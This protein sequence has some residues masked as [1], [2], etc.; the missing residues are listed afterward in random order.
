MSWHRL[1]MVVVALFLIGCSPKIAIRVDSIVDQGK[2]PPEKKYILY[3]RMKGTS[4]NDL[5]FREYSKYFREILKKHGY[6]QENQAESA[7]LAIYFSYGITGG[8]EVHHT[9]TRPVYAIVGGETVDIRETETDAEGKKI[10]T[11]KTVTIPTRRRVVGLETRRESYR[12]FTAHAV[13]EA[14][15]INEAK[16]HTD[17]SMQTLWKTTITTTSKLNDLRRIMPMMAAASTP[18]LGKNTGEM[19]TVKLRDNDDRVLE[20]KRL[21]SIA[22]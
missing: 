5:Y 15:E 12:V 6:R 8:E 21:R 3:S 17:N 4:V 1:I 7:D 11:T 22:R 9:Y 14:K 13:L 16:G 18:Y 20:M 19:V 2:P 10:E